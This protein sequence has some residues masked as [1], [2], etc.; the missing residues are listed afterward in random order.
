MKILSMARLFPGILILAAAASPAA[1]IVVDN[2]DGAPG[3]TETGSWSTSTWPGYNDG[4]YRY[5][6]GSG[7]LSTATWTPE[8]VFRGWY[9]VR[10]AFRRG[11]NRTTSAPYTITHALGQTVVYV[12]QSGS[13]VDEVVLGEF[14][15]ETGTSGSVRLENTGGSG[16]YIADAVIFHPTGDSPPVFTEIGHQ[17]RFPAAAESVWAY[18]DVVDDLGVTSVTMTYSATPSGSSD[19]V[20][21][22]DDGNHGDDAAGDGIWGAQIPGFP[23]GEELTYSFTATDTIGQSTTSDPGTY[24]VGDTGP[25]EYRVIWVDSWNAGI[26]NASQVDDLVATCRANN[27]NTIMPEIRKIGDAYY[28]SSIEPRAT[29]IS[30]GPSFDPLGYLL[31]VAHDTS[32]GKK[33]IEI[34]GWFVAQRIW[35]GGTLPP[36]H[37]LSQHPEYIM[38]DV[39]GNT[40]Y[41]GKNYL[42][43]GHPDAV[44]HNVAV[45]LDCMSKYNL[46]GVNLDYIRYP[47]S[48]WGYNPVSV[49]RFNAVYGRSGQPDPDDPDWSDWRRE[50]VSLEVRKIYVKMARIDPLVVLTTDTVQWGS[51]YDDFEASSAYAGVFQDWVGWLEDGII[52]YNALMNYATSDS[53]FQGWTDL[54]LAHD[55]KRG[56]IIGIG[57][58]LQTRVQDGMDQLL[59]ARNAGAAGLNIYDWG[60]EVNSTSESRTD[61][62]NALHAQVYPEWADPPDPVWKH[63]PTLGIFEGTV[64]AEGEPVDHAVVSLDGVPGQRTVSDGS[65]WYGLIDVP[66]GVYTL[67]F[68]RAP[69]PDRTARAVIGAGG[70]IVTIGVDLALGVGNVLSTY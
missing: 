46:D 51:S 36:D 42:D 5:T 8:I 66:P 50:C 40:S 49:A 32:G 44:D 14:L 10:A 1:D 7:T 55:G 62:Y 9:E 41:N 52:D 61:F 30:G 65:G 11:S 12:D 3:Y 29:N 15:F 57:A 47:G 60:S 31:Q 27:I 21:A 39:D 58:Y 64:L 19:T 37:V 54:S 68:S 16:A 23:D 13:G 4:T 56:S 28:D 34:H 53:R 18:A 26:L 45:I 63:H 25:R 35:T 6:E 24:R 38:S 22:W 43:P 67:R 48:T 70:E 2:D 17:P 33:R 20:P 69:W 59:Y